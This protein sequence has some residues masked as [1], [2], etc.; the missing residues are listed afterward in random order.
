MIYLFTALYCEAHIFIQQFHLE[1]DPQS[2]QF[3]E[4]YNETAGIRL[5]ITGIGEIAAAAAV[6][7]VCTAYKPTEGD[8]LLNIGTCACA[9]GRDGVFVCNK[10]TE[11]ATGKTFY[12]DILYRHEFQ[13][14][15]IVTGMLPWNREGSLLTGMLP[16]NREETAVTGAMVWDGE[17]G[18]MAFQ[19]SNTAASLYD[20]EAAAIY[21]AGAYFFGPHQMMF[22]KVVSDEGAAKEVSREQI[23]HLM[24]T[25]RD[26]LFG[27]IEQLQKIAHKN[28]PK[29]NDLQQGKEALI[30]KLCM[31]MHC[32]KVMR[33]SLRQ[34]IRYLTLAGT[35]YVSV[36]QDMYREGLLP[37]NDKREGKLRFE[38]FKRRLF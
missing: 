14:E 1:K 37:C 16:R 35:D 30:E 9:A 34:H 24:E 6:S 12:P 2:T 38:E 19:A 23:E 31:D 29:T 27:Y 13:E 21:Q 3:Q 22:L 26:G 7:S 32:S 28:A 11:L 8:V 33:D 4:F 10:I 20:M 18:S 5:T 17:K 15:G 36:I 25:Y